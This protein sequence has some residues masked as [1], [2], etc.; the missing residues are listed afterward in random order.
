MREREREREREKYTKTYEVSLRFIFGRDSRYN[1]RQGRVPDIN[2]P[3]DTHRDKQI[4][5]VC[6]CTYIYV[7]KRERERE[8]QYVLAYLNNSNMNIDRKSVV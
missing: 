8:S 7:C 3:T 4:Q 1:L 5:C 2:P 6:V